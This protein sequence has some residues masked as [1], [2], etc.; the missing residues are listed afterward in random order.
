M[1]GQCILTNAGMQIPSAGTTPTCHNLPSSKHDNT[2]IWHS[3]RSLALQIFWKV[4]S[5]PN[6]PAWQTS[7]SIPLAASAS[8][9]A[10]QVAV[11]SNATLTVALHTVEQPNRV[12]LIAVAGNPTTPMVSNGT[13]GTLPVQCQPMGSVEVAKGE[14][15][16]QFLFE[17]QSAGSESET[18]IQ[19]RREVYSHDCLWSALV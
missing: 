5:A 15:V 12:Q 17:P 11:S 7:P 1:A 10:A 3:I 2:P 18:S 14:T 9:S 16:V 13:E 4:L 8:V 19:H 6:K